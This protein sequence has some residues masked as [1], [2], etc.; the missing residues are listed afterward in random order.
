MIVA[1]LVAHA[2]K[3]ESGLCLQRCVA[4]EACN[5]FLKAVGITKA[6][7]STPLGGVDETDMSP[8][9][10]ELLGR[11]VSKI[12]FR[13]ACDELKISCKRLEQVERDFKNCVSLL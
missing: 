7:H 5:T 2:Y 12:P 1:L 9:N 3:T 10:A 13:A 6:I 11:E 8:A 4:F